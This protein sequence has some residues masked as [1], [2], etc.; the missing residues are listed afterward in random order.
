MY[1]G[2]ISVVP[3]T[4]RWEETGKMT[5]NQAVDFSF[6]EFGCGCVIFYTTSK[7]SFSTTTLDFLVNLS[8]T[9]SESAFLRKK[10]LLVFLLYYY[11]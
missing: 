2:Y 1:I 3:G 9:A 5:L 10:K 8:L 11:S 7:Y 4:I 6:R